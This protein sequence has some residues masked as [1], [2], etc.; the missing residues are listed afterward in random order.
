MKGL[1]SRYSKIAH[2]FFPLSFTAPCSV[3]WIKSIYFYFKLYL[4]DFK[5]SGWR[6]KMNAIIQVFGLYD[7]RYQTLR[8]IWVIG[9]VFHYPD[10]CG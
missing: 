2:P 8:A 1:T 7:D 5:T 3:L 10:V 6:V 4:H 9:V